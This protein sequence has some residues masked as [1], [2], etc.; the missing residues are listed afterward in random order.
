VSGVP[1]LHPPL[2]HT[3]REGGCLANLCPVTCEKGQWTG[4]ALWR[5][6]L[7]SCGASKLRRVF[8]LV[9]EFYE[10]P[11]FFLSFF[12]LLSFYRSTDLSV[13]YVSACRVFEADTSCS[14][15]ELCSGLLR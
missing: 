15:S 10:H 5:L 11:S 9:S 4:A 2:P 8:A 12:L 7:L 14:V 3:P 6:L 13:L 1:L